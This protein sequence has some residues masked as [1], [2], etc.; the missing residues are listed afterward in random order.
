[1]RRMGGALCPVAE[2]S[3]SKKVLAANLLLNH[4]KKCSEPVWRRV[5]NPWD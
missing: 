3:S 1:M 5:F 4:S 2:E